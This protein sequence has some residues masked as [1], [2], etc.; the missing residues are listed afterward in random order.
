M[1]LFKVT[2]QDRALNRYSVNLEAV[3]WAE[4]IAMAFGR[5]TVE[6]KLISIECLGDYVDGVF[7]PYEKVEDRTEKSTKEIHEEILGMDTGEVE[8]EDYGRPMRTQ[9]YFDR[10]FGGKKDG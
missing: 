2:Y 5:K 10:L 8:E 6:E 1:K 7:V 9:E 4:A 3:Q